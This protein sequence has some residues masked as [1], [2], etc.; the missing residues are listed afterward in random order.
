MSVTTVTVTVHAECD[1][2]FTY[3]ILRASALER[4]VNSDLSI[5]SASQ[6]SPL[7]V[8]VEVEA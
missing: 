1:A 5:S 3:P 4:Q 6:A 7:N 8:N 2:L